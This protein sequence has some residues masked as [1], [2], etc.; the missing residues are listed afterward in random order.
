VTVPS[1][2]DSLL[3]ALL[4]LFTVLATSPETNREAAAV[5]DIVS[6]VQRGVCGELDRNA[7]ESLYDATFQ[8]DNNEDIMQHLTI[9]SLL[10]CVDSASQAGRFAYLGS[11]LE[12]SI[13][14]SYFVSI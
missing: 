5:R 12:A 4:T 7:F 6:Q 14:S 13:C 3:Q 10:S 8:G 11:V 1:T 2:L 9:I